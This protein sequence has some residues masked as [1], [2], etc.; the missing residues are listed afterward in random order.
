MYGGATEHLLVVA[1]PANA[2]GFSYQGTDSA[3]AK[4]MYCVQEAVTNHSTQ[5]TAKFTSC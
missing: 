5:L 1:A 2:A 3:V 4:Q